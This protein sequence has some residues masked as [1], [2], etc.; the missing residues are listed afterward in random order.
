MLACRAFLFLKGASRSQQN[1]K[2]RGHRDSNFTCCKGVKAHQLPSLYVC[3]LPQSPCPAAIPSAASKVCVT[4]GDWPAN[5]LLTKRKIR[6]QRDFK[7]DSVKEEEQVRV[8]RVTNHH[9]QV[10][11]ETEGAR[12]HHGAKNHLK[13]AEINATH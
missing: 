10:V 9:T 6:T 3:S 1:R 7:M 11:L 8:L 5:E 12:L 2:E 4:P 13:G